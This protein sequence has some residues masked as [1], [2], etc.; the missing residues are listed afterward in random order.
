VDQ[1]SGQN[2]EG[3]GMASRDLKAEIANR[4][5]RL[6]QFLVVGICIILNITDGFDSAAMSNA[7]PL[8]RKVFGISPQMLGAIFSFQAAGMVLGAIFMAP[9]ADRFGRRNIILAA[10]ILLTA[11]MAGSTLANNA[12]SLSVLRLCTGI[13]MGSMIVSLN[14]MIVEYSNAKWG[15][16][17][18]AFMHSGFAVGTTISGFIS[19]AVVDA[20]G[21][22]GIF[23]VG[24]LGNA[25][26]CLL[27]LA[28]LPESLD[29]LLVRQPRNSLARANGVLRKIGG[30]PLEDLPPLAP[31]ASRPKTQITAFLTPQLMAPTLLL[32][33][34]SFL[35]YVISYFQFQWT[36]TILASAGLSQH[37]ALSSHSVT[38]TAAFIGNLTMGFFAARVGAARLTGIYFLLAAVSLLAVGFLGP[39]P[40]A[41]LAAAG[42]ASLFIQGSFTGLVINTTRFYPSEVRNTGTGFMLG[43]GRLGGI[44]GPS[45]AGVAMGLGW[46]RA[47]FY[48]V[49]AALAVLAAITIF[50]L[51]V[52]ARRNAAAGLTPDQATTAAHS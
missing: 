31:V 23:G 52:L 45:V 43:V 8:V 33:A 48:P 42:A 9:L 13:A 39:Q 47:H 14:V 22:R 11:A 26:I 12:E 46:Q 10:S 49:F 19:I 5:M 37:A 1:P 18:L 38:G 34:T 17:L 29:F 30:E 2:I 24:A 25:A 44:V 20:Y 3:S 7:A 35:Y 40:A 6:F 41:L 28:F 50:S 16:L 4:P 21:W 36:P 51:G 15:N 27:G 32:W